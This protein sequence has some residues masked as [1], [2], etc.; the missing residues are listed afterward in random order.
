MRKYKKPDLRISF[1]E[2]EDIFLLSNLEVGEE[3]GGDIGGGSSG[4]IVD[5]GMGEFF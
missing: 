4:E 5:P 2:E 3:E 1:M